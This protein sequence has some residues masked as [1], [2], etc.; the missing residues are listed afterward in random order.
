MLTYIVAASQ[1]LLCCYMLRFT[2]ARVDN[3]KRMCKL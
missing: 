1:T 3:L 2:R